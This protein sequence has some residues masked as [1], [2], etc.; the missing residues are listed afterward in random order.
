[1]YITKE[2][3]QDNEIW[4]KK[5]NFIQNSFKVSSGFGLIYWRNS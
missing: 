2:R 5:K 1:M 3:Q 4:N